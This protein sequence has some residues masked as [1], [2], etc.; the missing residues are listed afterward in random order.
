MGHAVAVEPVELGLDESLDHI[1]QRRALL[2]ARILEVGGMESS[3]VMVVVARRRSIG[4]TLVEDS[5][6]PPAPCEEVN[7]GAEIA[8]PVIRRSGRQIRATGSRLP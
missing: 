1:G 3:G 8:L 2:G 4:A 7:A 5:R 6:P